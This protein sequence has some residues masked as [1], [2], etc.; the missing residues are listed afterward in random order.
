V[1]TEDFT[2]FGGNDEM[3][4]RL[5]YVVLVLGVMLSNA[6]ENAFFDSESDN[7]APGVPSPEEDVIARITELKNDGVLEKIEDL[8]ADALEGVLTDADMDKLY[9]FFNEPDMALKQIAQEENGEAQVDVINALFNEGTVDDV[10][11]ALERLSPEKVGDLENMLDELAEAM[12]ISNGETTLT[13]GV[14]FNRSTTTA[15][16]NIRQMKL[17]LSDSPSVPVHSGYSM[18]ITRNVIFTQE[19]EWSTVAAYSGVCVAT[20][21]ASFLAESYLPWVKIPGIVV[22]IAGGGTAVAQLIFWGNSEKLWDVLL[23][24]I[25]QDE[26]ELA[27]ILNSSD[28]VFQLLT[29]SAVTLATTEVCRVT[30]IGRFVTLDLLPIWERFLARISK[31]LPSG[32]SFTIAGITIPSGPPIANP[33][34][35]VMPKPPEP[36]TWIEEIIDWLF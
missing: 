14:L 26:E 31:M 6:C 10:L 27:N 12:Q 23:N 18:P 4:K 17:R 1:K 11:Q 25:E 24:I 8:R 22:A 33:P 34:P 21:V 13:G 32:F 16:P 5:F 15:K 36:K 7:P 35:P 2:N 29:I 30:V 28:K 3:M 19:M 20:V 9:L